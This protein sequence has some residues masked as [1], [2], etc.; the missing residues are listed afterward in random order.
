MN[1]IKKYFSKSK[2][3]ISVILT[4]EVSS[5]DVN[6]PEFADFKIVSCYDILEKYNYHPSMDPYA[7]KLDCI[8]E[9]IIR[10]EDPILICNTG[11]SVPDID[12]LSEM[13]NPHELSIDKILIPNESKRKKKLAE[14]QEAYKNHSRWLNFY[15][16][17]IEDI[18]HEFE[19]KIEGLKSRYKNTGT[20][21]LEV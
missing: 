6:T 14:G 18:Y 5:S 10:S 15:P 17:E 9:E 2:K 7:R 3:K 13:L 4:L 1:F 20:E 21:V 12:A 11:L 16:G 8:C 19:A